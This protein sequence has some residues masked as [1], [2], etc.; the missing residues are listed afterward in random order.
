MAAA[1]VPV[2]PGGIH[3]G[4]EALVQDAL[5]V[6]RHLLFLVL[7]AVALALLEEARR[8]H[9]AGI[10]HDYRLL[11]ARQRAYRVPDG[12][13]R[14]FVEHHQVERRRL[15]RQILRDGK[16]AHQEAWLERRE[17]RARLRDELAH[18][19]APRLLAAFAPDHAEF[20]VGVAGGAGAM[21]QRS[22]EARDDGEA[23][24]AG[25]FG[26]Q[27]AETRHP[28][29]LAQTRKLR[30]FRRM[31]KYRRKH[32]G[33]VCGVERA[34][35]VRAVGATLRDE[36]GERARAQR[37][38]APG[39]LAPAHHVAEFADA[40]GQPFAGKRELA[41][42]HRADVVGGEARVFAESRLERRPL[43][44]GRRRGLAH[45]L[46]RLRRLVDAAAGL[47]AEGAF[48]RHQFAHHRQVAHEACGVGARGA[49]T[50]ETRHLAGDG[51]A[52]EKAQR[53][54][55]ARV[56]FKTAR[57]RIQIQLRKSVQTVGAKPLG[58]RG[59]ALAHF[60]KLLQQ[61]GRVPA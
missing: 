38:R 27:L 3:S 54:N 16:R 24:E 53:P 13:L 35:G 32:L 52:A 46:R 31:R 5:L 50:D 36:N 45:A 14:G 4:G 47:F 18:R 15:Q 48:E 21:R 58:E 30:Q 7:F 6:G 41:Q 9:L 39:R 10:A 44:V 34:N 17:D 56:R 28:L 51:A 40:I 11:A 49:R 26:V 23:G 42:R 8:R 20:G 22:G 60:E 43:H 57:K 33:G 37:R 61:S 12:D 55:A 25:A 1:V 2:E 29:V 59:M 19:L